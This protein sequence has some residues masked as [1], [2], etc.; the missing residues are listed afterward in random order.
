MKTSF[1]RHL[2]LPGIALATL[3]GWATVH[4][5]E[6]PKKAPLTRYS[7]LWNESPFTT[8]PP[9]IT[10]ENPVNEFE[11]K[12]LRGVAPLVNGGYL[13]TLVDKKTPTDTITID[14]ERSSEYEVIKIERHPDKHLGTIVHLKKGSMVGTVAYD[15]KLSVPKPPT[16]PKQN[17]AGQAPPGAPGATPGAPN[18]P[19]LPG[20]IRPPRQ[21]VVTPGGPTGAPTTTPTGGPG[22]TPPT[23][24]GFNRGGP[25]SSS[26]QSS[27]RP[28][29]RGFQ[30]GGDRPSRR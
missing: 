13:I 29:I 10:P 4:A 24:G 17:P 2:L 20:G 23:T 16:P 26:S 21:R 6:V 25:G 12:A 19:T 30:R 22:I 7:A 28:D 14:T 11:N 9:P 1:C 27:G 15:E 18:Q 3:A 8:K 5:V